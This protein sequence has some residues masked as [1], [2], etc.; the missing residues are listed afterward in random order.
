[1]DPTTQV[2]HCPNC[3]QPLAAYMQACGR[4]G[5]SYQL[6]RPLWKLTPTLLICGLGCML[7]ICLL[8]LLAMV[9]GGVLAPW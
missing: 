6:P 4:C 1:M 2:K 5:Y 8:P 9:F 7:L 3:G